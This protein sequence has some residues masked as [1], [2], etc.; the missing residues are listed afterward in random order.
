M[1]RKREILLLSSVSAISAIAGGLIFSIFK[2]L[3]KNGLEESISAFKEIE[4]KK[5][6]A[7]LKAFIETTSHT[8]DILSDEVK[9]L[10]EVQ[11][12]MLGSDGASKVLILSKQVE[13]LSKALEADILKTDELVSSLMIK[14]AEN[15]DE[16]KKLI[17][18]LT[19]SMELNKIE[20]S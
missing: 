12:S 5:E 17:S 7:D 19:V 3:R 15:F 13:D 11:E 20:H 10:S 2:D 9:L 8:V 18:G 4:I 6:I 16:L 14:N 1:S